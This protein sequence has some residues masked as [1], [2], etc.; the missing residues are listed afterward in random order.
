LN[1]TRGKIDHEDK[2]SLNEV[3]PEDSV[4]ADVDRQMVHVDRVRALA[5]PELPD[6]EPR[7]QRGLA[8]RAFAAPHIWAF[9]GVRRKQA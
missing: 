8:G 3:F 5:V 2:L 1:S 4:I 7:L 9:A 6:I